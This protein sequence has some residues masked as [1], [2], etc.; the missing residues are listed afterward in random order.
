VP[1]RLI[2]ITTALVVVGVAAVAAIVSYEHACALVHAHGVDGWTAHLLPLTV[3]GLIYSSSM[4][5]LQSARRPVLVPVL[6]V[7]LLALGI[8][9]TL[10]ANVMHGLGHG[11]VG[12]A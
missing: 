6:A 4:V 7:W 9:A 11:P 3:D 12:A 1:D 8:L 5:M 2:R 10:A